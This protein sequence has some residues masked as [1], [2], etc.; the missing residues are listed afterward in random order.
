MSKLFTSYPNYNHLKGTI[1]RVWVHDTKDE[2]RNPDE[3]TMIA[4]TKSYVKVLL[5]RD[6]SL[7]GKQAIVK[8]IDIFKW[9]VCAEIIDRNPKTI[10]VKFED[11]FKGMYNPQKEKGNLNQFSQIKNEQEDIHA[12][13][14]NKSIKKTTSLTE[15]KA[16]II[17]GILIYILSVVFLFFGLSNLLK[18]L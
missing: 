11:H 10:N 3:E 4:H 7:I 6:P 14:I 16:N 2:G 8:I 17:P 1:Q 5:K 15:K 12:T 18:D 9:H 13:I